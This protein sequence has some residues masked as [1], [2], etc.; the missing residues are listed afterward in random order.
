MSNQM[1]K[2]HFR[3][4]LIYPYPFSKIPKHNE[5][6]GTGNVVPPIINVHISLRLA[7]S[8]TFPPLL[9][10][11]IVVSRVEARGSSLVP[12]IDGMVSG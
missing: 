4:L 1:K 5:V 12:S 10:Q 3:P 11:N 6:W 9:T 2:S 7:N 8:N